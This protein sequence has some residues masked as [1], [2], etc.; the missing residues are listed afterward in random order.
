[1]AMALSPDK[2]AELKQIIHNYLSQVLATEPSRLHGYSSPDLFFYSSFYSIPVST[3]SYSIS[4][5]V[6]FS[7]LILKRDRRSHDNHKI[8]KMRSAVPSVY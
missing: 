6:I 7:T 2:V 3:F 1:M 5:P 4:I 8:T